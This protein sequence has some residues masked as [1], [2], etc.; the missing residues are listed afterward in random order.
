MPQPDD[1]DSPSSATIDLMEMDSEM[2]DSSSLSKGKVD[3]DATGSVASSSGRGARMASSEQLVQRLRSASSKSRMEV[4]VLRE[5]LERARATDIELLTS[6]FDDVTLDLRRTRQRNSELRERVR[7]LEC[8]KADGYAAGD[9][10][11]G[12]MPGRTV[13]GSD[14]KT[15]STS[16]DS[17]RIAGATRTYKGSVTFDPSVV[18]PQPRRRSTH[19]AGNFTS[20]ES[21]LASLPGRER[22][23]FT[24]AIDSRLKIARLADR[25][26]IDELSSQL[27]EL[28]NDAGTNDYAQRDEHSFE[29]EPNAN[30]TDSIPPQQST[31]TAPPWSA[32]HMLIWFCVGAASMLLCIAVAL[33]S[34]A[35]TLS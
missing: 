5:A 28:L 35:P 27:R 7:A 9:V 19:G 20:Y 8:A 2:G 26:V 25:A 31:E 11:G 12:G 10:R 34:S 6:Q 3:G 15:A 32:I 29:Q 21:I 1:V 24:D 4:L 13:E 14:E 33:W 16:A 30:E 17:N 23:V 18:D 22:Q